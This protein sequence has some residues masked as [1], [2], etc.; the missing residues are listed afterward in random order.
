[1]RYNCMSRCP[2]SSVGHADSANPPEIPQVSSASGHSV[3]KSGQCQVSD[4]DLARLILAW[5]SLSPSVRM[6]ML[7]L[8]ESAD[9]GVE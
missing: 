4:P 7:A 9:K 5:P 2:R 6:N 1:M 3:D 8:I